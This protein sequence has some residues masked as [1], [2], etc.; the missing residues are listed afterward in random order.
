MNRSG[1]GSRWSAPALRRRAGPAGPEL[2]EISARLEIGDP[3]EFDDDEIRRA[4]GMARRNV[5]QNLW[6][7]FVAVLFALFL[8][9]VIWSV[10]S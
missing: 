9:V 7:V 10:G 8:G 4:M 5:I 2:I 6:Y 1:A 3:V